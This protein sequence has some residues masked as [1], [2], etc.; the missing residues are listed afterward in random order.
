MYVLFLLLY[1]LLCMCVSCSNMGIIFWFDHLKSVACIWFLPC[2][3]VLGSNIY[4]DAVNHAP[5]PAP[6]Q[7]SS[8][9]SMLGGIGSTIAQGM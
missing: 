2:L 4:F 7:A 6:V 9:G 5:P 3:I 8:G 1:L